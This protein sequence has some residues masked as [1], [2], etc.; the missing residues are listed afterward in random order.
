VKK[1]LIGLGVVLALLAV[2]VL[3]LFLNLNAVIEKG[4]ETAGPDM[5][6]APVEV[7]DVDVSLFSGRG[8][9]RGLTVGN[10]EGYA[11]DHAFRLGSVEVELD[12]RSV[13]SDIIQIRRVRVVAPEIAYVGNLK[14]SN[15]QQLQR[16]AEAFAA[17]TPADPAAGD[18]AAGP[19]LAI[20]S[21]EIENAQVGV[22]LSFLGNEPMSVT[23]PSLV[24]KDLGKDGQTGVADVLRQV[25]GQLGRSIVPLIRDK[26]GD[27]GTPLRARAQDLR[28]RAEEGVDKLKSLFSR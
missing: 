20:D 21:L 1:I 16:N 23:L 7:A 28:D 5:L 26:A 27:L 22:V 3:V 11:G 17:A 12:P 18:A 6:K 10:P 25:L 13:T 8:I 24:M 19:S 14:D 4:I 2:A 9:I 15:L